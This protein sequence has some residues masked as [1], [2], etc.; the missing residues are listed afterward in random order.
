[1][2]QK[3]GILCFTL[4]Y[5]FPCVSRLQG[6]PSI[7]SLCFHIRFL[8]ILRFLSVLIP[9]GLENVPREGESPFKP[10]GKLLRQTLVP[11]GP[12]AQGRGVG[13]FGSGV[14]GKLSA[15]TSY[16]K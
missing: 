8:T 14:C 11:E 2:T 7:C 9:V 13:R 4:S 1:M 16:R 3:L 15:M 10:G 12:W 6:T 5:I